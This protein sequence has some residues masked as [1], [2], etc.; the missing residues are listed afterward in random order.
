MAASR[1]VDAGLAAAGPAVQD[2]RRLHVIGE[3]LPAAQ[4]AEL[5]DDTLS[6]WKGHGASGG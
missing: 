6:A 2:Q 4:L 3:A 5:P 1:Q